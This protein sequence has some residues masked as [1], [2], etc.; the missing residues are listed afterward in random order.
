[1]IKVL[2]FLYNENCFA[3]HGLSTTALRSRMLNRK[4][5]NLKFLQMTVGFEV[6]PSTLRLLYQPVS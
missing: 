4:W 6:T 1:M 5:L 3:G 2:G